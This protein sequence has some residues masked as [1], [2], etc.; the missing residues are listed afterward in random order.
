MSVVR[1]S[2]SLR[3]EV[4]DI[5][6]KIAK[7]SNTTRS[8]VITSAI[9]SY[10]MDRKWMFGKDD[11]DVG[12]AIIVLYETGHMEAETS[13]THAQHEY[14]EQI[15][16]ALHVHLTEG[17]CLEVIVVKGKL[18]DIKDLARKIEGKKGILAVRYSIHPLK[19]S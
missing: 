9:E 6:D 3:K 18:K 15:K 1:T 10:V 17:L 13:L 7:E 16:A 19:P 4:M 8:W 11:E 2:I 5:L 14:L 12:G